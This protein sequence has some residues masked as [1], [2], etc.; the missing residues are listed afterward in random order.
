MG[1]G[2]KRT[3]KNKRN[4]AVKAEPAP[5]RAQSARESSAK[6][7]TAAPTKP[8]A[9]KRPIRSP[10]DI[11]KAVAT[12]ATPAVFTEPRRTVAAE[13][14]QAATDARQPVATEV[15]R[16]ATQAPVKRRATTPPKKHPKAPPFFRKPVFETLEPR[17]LLSADLNPAAQDTVFAMPAMQGAEYRALVE[18]GAQPSIT[19]MQ[20]APIQ[21]TNE[22][23]FV[24]TATRDY[25]Q[26][27]DDMRGNALAQGRDLEVV[28][29]D[30]E[31][32]GIRKIADALAQKANLDAIHI[33]SHAVDGAVQLGAAQLDFATLAERSAAIR[34]WGNA[35]T[36]DGDLLIYGCDLAAT[37]SGQSLVDE[38]ARVAGADVAASE[39]PTGA[40]S[41][42]GN[43][44]LEFT[45]GAIEAKVAVSAAEQARW[46]AL[47]APPVVNLNGSSGTI[48]VA[49]DTFGSSTYSGG[50]GWS[51]DWVEFDAS[52]TRF[53]AGTSNSDNTPA[54]GNVVY[55]TS[56]GTGVD[57]SIAFVGHGNQF[58]DSIQR[59]V[60][61]LSYTTATLTFT[62][63]LQNVEAPDAL[64]VQASKDG[65]ATFTTLG[66]PYTTNTGGSYLNSGNIDISSYISDKTVIRFAVTGGFGETDDR[67]F[68]DNVTIT[69]SGRNYNTTFTEGGA[70]VAIASAAATVSD[71]D[72]SQFIGATVTLT[73]PQAGDVLAIGGALPGGIA[74]VVSG[75]TVALSG[76]ASAANYAAALN[77]IT[78]SNTSNAPN[79]TTRT[80]SVQVTDA[81]SE[82]SLA[83]TSFV[84]VVSVDSAAVAQPDSFSGP[85]FGSITG[86][87]MA[88]NGAGT[89][90]DVDAVSPL[91]VS[92]TLVAGPTQGTVTLNSDGSFTYTPTGTGSYTDTFQYR[93][94]SLAQVPGTTYEYWSAPPAGNN[95]ATGFPTTA[96]NAT[97]FLSGYDVDQAAL[98]SGDADLN[99]F[100]LRFTSQ[101]DVTTGGTY[102]FY[103]GSDDG[104][105]VY[106]DGA[107]VVNN[108]G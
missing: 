47:L 30:A 71:P 66:F 67:F 103:S 2:I 42:G 81:T 101:F 58:N 96:P 20:V 59:S 98:N 87:V 41:K 10:L 22:I 21:R 54:S 45:T 52:P 77:L 33:V 55:G 65:G 88:D 99:N 39:D 72:G 37:Q 83:A 69:A 64:V 36:D 104:S 102:T 76:T 46:D 26:L 25:Q 79:T 56:A 106:I 31:R 34:T 74:G 53:I 84:R 91:S 85:N 38:I 95:L 4:R 15:K 44:K 89:D 23:A 68:F 12:A 1:S 70:A 57:T 19:S 92:T 17:L 16:A 6:L 93:L 73:N 61:L 86:N 75:N 97:G 18:P 105:R 80:L 50:S 32:D 11:A 9:S 51:S 90:S 78:F 49:T 48:T 8:A 5:P 13:A 3:N 35:L 27:V 29:I 107:L 62:Y 43:W 94:I 28:L 24:D 100:T 14:K 82:T 7:D 40:A 108:D 63:K 60:N